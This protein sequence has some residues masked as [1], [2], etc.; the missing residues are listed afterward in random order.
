MH[1]NLETVNSAIKENRAHL[2]LYVL[3]LFGA[4]HF[5]HLQITYANDTC[6]LYNQTFIPLVS[7]YIKV[8]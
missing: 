2:S 5:N 3:F 1:L 4:F 7:E 8:F 6:K